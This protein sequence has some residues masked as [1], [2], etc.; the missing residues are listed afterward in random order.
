MSGHFAATGLQAIVP[1]MSQA[2]MVLDGLPAPRGP[3]RLTHLNNTIRQ[4]QQ[5]HTLARVHDDRP[6]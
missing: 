6:S 5:Q 3:L 1:C 2:S 4:Q